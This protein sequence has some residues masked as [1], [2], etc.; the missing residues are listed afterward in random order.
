MVEILAL[1]MSQLLGPARLEVL[2]RASAGG[3][4][5]LVWVRLGMIKICNCRVC[6]NVNTFSQIALKI[7]HVK[8]RFSVAIILDVIKSNKSQKQFCEIKRY[9]CI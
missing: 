7:P 6:Y 3:L 4:G 5:H 9:V 8:I 1:V 2:L